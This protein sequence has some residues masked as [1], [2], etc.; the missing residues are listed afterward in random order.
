MFIHVGSHNTG[1]YW[2][3]IYD[4]VAKLWRKYNDEK[5]TEVE[6]IREIFE[7]P[8]TS[9]PPTPY[10]LVYVKDE[11][12]EQ[13]VDPVCRSVTEPPHEEHADVT[14]QDYE[15]VPIMNGADSITDQ[16]KDTY[17]GIHKPQTQMQQ[18]VADGNAFREPD[19]AYDCEVAW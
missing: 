10:Y 5:V 15:D 1:H 14:M 17:A 19:E 12:K 18:V 8:G 9:R 11:M 6:D 4:F 16:I 2:I 13:L 3:Y 7:A